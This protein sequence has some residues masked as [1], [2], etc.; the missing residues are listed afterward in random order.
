[1]MDPQDPQTLFAAMY[2]RQRKAWGFN[3]GGP[4]SGIF[5]SRDGGG[6]WTRLSNGLPQGDKGRIGLDVFRAD[7][8]VIFAVVEAAGRES[9]VYR[10][11]DR[12]D[13]WQA[14]STI[15]PRPMYFSQIRADPK[16][17]LR[18]YLLGSN[19]GFY[20]SND[21][22]KT[23]ADVFSTIHS[24]DHALWIDPDDTNHLI[25][26]GDGGVSI[27]WDRGQ[28][29][30]FRDNLPVGQFYEISADM[31]DPYVICGGLQDN[32]HWCVPSA[33][34]ARTGISNHD[35]FNIGGG[36]G[37]YA[38]LDP[39]DPRTAIIESQDGRANR[40][41]LSTLER[42]AIAPL[43]PSRLKPGE[44]ER[45]NWNTPI[46]MSTFDPRTLYMGSHMIF[47]S[48]DRGATW[49][50]ISPDLTA[51]I[52][53]ESL[54]MMGAPVPERALSRHDG[55]TS[56][57]T[58]TTIGES[59]LDAKVLY[60]GSDDG[61]LTVT[62][63]GGEKWSDLNERIPG[64]P[65]R[66]YVSSV[67]PSR[68]VA[69]R[70]YATFD[71][72]YDDDY[73]AYVYVS[74]DYGQ[75]W[76]SIASG[77]PAASV[78]KLREHPR[79]GRLL[80]VGHERGIHFSI[81]GGASWSPLTL[82]MPTVP[83]DDIL[84]HPRE[85]DLIAGTHGR[86]IWVL[87]NISSLE[88]LTPDAMRKDAFLVPPARARLLS[89]YNPQAW[90]GA[91]QFFAPNPAFG[92]AIDYY[93]RDGSGDQVRV[94]ISDARGVTVRTINGTSH[95]GLNRAS[96]DLRMEP[97]APNG[98][99]DVPAAGGFG[100]A[101][102]GP[103]VLPGVYGVTVNAA[104]HLLKGE[105]RVD[106]D[107]R[108]NFSDADR[109]IRQ[110]ALLNLYA[111]QKSLAAARA[112]GATAAGQLD[113]PGPGGVTS[114]RADAASRLTRVQA[115]LVA[116]F[117]AVNSLSRAIEGYSGLPTADQRRQLDWAFE[118]AARAIAAMNALLQT[119]TAPSKL[120]VPTKLTGTR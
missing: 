12:G 61:R 91:G 26:G 82:N 85:N 68:H 28:T 62:R 100:G 86:S 84:I 119:D 96:W 89:L 108:I 94:T 105:L 101:P 25:I 52:D 43:P 34:R 92:A 19:R 42:Q 111:L 112:A 18:V 81:D 59:P 14:W 49:K 39:A 31:Q 17:P 4:G 77:L 110:T 30:L 98:A 24:E 58:L 56:F 95:A 8:R 102:Q 10:S 60:A 20:I 120:T 104:G 22:G 115:D 48:V 29:W 40:V 79:N 97:P 33:T 83:V 109:R 11:A 107:L 47:K 46:V 80:F 66:T 1:M 53:R 116:Q 3:G 44:H 75:T 23:F 74:E 50:A 65:A 70:V 57:S 114:S 36:D 103:L 21:G 67:L 15:N 38:R 63:D 106:G 6:T 35:G 7:P 37:F 27:S 32:G 45:W 78:H 69:G 64:L 90:Y 16:D 93:L 51:A 72:H 2:Q 118:D 41:N 76:R 71:G 88:A 54:Q 9:G 87:D 55:V 13:T 117:N 73:R 5:R 113:T 99:R